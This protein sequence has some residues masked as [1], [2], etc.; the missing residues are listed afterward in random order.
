METFSD[1]LET[2]PDYT[3]TFPEHKAAIFHP[4]DGKCE[5]F[6]QAVRKTAV[7]NGMDQGQHHTVEGALKS[8]YHGKTNYERS[9]LGHR[10][11]SSG[12]RQPSALIYAAQPL[13]PR[14]S[15]SLAGSS[16]AGRAF[17]QHRPEGPHIPVVRRPGPATCP[18][19]Y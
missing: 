8:E 6:E 19:R 10:S 1:Q 2:S 4:C 15:A 7:Y 16:H 9:L 5:D 3:E 12:I 17:K 18:G 13:A 14:H 11:A